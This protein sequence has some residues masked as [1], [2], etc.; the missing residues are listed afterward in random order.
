MELE[1][2]KNYL[3]IDTNIE[4]EQILEFI[5]AAKEYIKGAGVLV[6]SGHMYNLAVSMV[7]C[8]FYENRGILGD[9]AKIIPHGINT[10]LMKL[11]GLKL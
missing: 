6:T 2:I 10:I 11:K 8:H 9:N 7:V 3:R 1:R 4:D 5:L